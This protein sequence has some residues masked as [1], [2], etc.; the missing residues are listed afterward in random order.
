MERPT[1]KLKLE[2]SAIFKPLFLDQTSSNSTSSIQHHSTRFKRT[3]HSV[4]NAS[5]HL[6]PIISIKRKEQTNKG[7]KEG[8]KEGRKKRRRKEML[9]VEAES[10]NLRE[11]LG[12]FPMDLLKWYASVGCR[13]I[14]TT[15][16]VIGTRLTGW[17]Y[18]SSGIPSE[19]DTSPNSWKNEGSQATATD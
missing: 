19:K 1:S 16:A 12:A 13:P 2:T 15:S 10:G 17:M 3:Q 4:L 11:I 14:T 6:N 7:R 9:K 8:R 18:S 5:I